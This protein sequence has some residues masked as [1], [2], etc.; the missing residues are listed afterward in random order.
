[1]TVLAID[2]VAPSYGKNHLKGFFL[3]NINKA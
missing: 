2:M 1:M 3:E